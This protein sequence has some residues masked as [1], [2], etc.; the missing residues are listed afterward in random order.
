MTLHNRILPIGY[1]LLFSV[2]L[3]TIGWI[4]KWNHGRSSS[5]KGGELFNIES[6]RSRLNIGYVMLENG[7]WL[8]EKQGLYW[9]MHLLFELDGSKQESTNHV[10]HSLKN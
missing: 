1:L 6:R 7:G 10:C 8:L 3:Y 5:K 2:L 9:K 4:I